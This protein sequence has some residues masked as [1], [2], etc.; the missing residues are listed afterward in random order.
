MSTL[1][2][3]ADGTQ[4]AQPSTATSAAA[5]DLYSDEELVK[6]LPGFT[7][8]YVTVNGI[9][10]HYVEG[11]SGEPLIC[12]PGWPQTWYSYHPIATQLAQHYRLIILD[13][14]GMGTSDKPRLGY[15]K[16][17]MAQDVYALTQLLGLPKVALLGH[18]IGGMV[19]LSFAFN[20]PAATT[21]VVLADGGHPSEGMRHMAMLPAPGTFEAKMDGNNPYMWWMSFNQIEGLPEQLLAGRFRYVLD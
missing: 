3:L 16:K 5:P 21:K 14:R 15:D 10:L 4:R 18:D 12:L 17:T 19:A 8:H 20:Y 6:K 11:G 9:R 2:T 7:N 1:I 13:I